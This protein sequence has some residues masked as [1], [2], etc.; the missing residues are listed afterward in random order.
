MV[1][2]VS[3]AGLPLLSEARLSRYSRV[4]HA[5]L[6]LELNETSK[7]L[8]SSGQTQMKYGKTQKGRAKAIYIEADKFPSFW[9]VNN[10]CVNRLWSANSG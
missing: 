2:N 7:Y 10:E 8:L 1:V 3:G 6:I 4:C 5:K 9:L